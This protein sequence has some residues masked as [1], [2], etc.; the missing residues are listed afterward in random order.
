MLEKISFKSFDRTLIDEYAE[1][2]KEFLQDIWT[3]EYE[4]YFLK[5]FDLAKN[6]YILLAM[7]KNKVIG[8]LFVSFEK[9]HAYVEEIEISAPFRKKGIGKKLL[10][11]FQEKF[12]NIPLE[13]LVDKNNT[14]AIGFYNKLGFVKQEYRNN[15][16]RLRYDEEKVTA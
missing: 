5:N 1:F 8:Q 14:N 16:Y 4:K 2:K 11:V 13:L 15:Y 6:Q 7:I 10:R 9:D 12:E 3:K